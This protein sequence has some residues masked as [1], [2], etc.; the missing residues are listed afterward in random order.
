MLKKLANS[1]MNALQRQIRPL[2]ER[3]DVLSYEQDIRLEE[4]DRSYR[5]WARIAG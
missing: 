1:R 4:L 3:Q 5:R 2:I